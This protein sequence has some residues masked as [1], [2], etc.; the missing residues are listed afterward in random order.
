MGAAIRSLNTNLNEFLGQDPEENRD[1]GN[2]PIKTPPV[3]AH[4]SASDAIIHPFQVRQQH[5]KH[6]AVAP[7]LSLRVNTSI[8]LKERN[9]VSKFG[10]S[11]VA[12]CQ[13][14]QYGNKYPVI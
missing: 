12:F 10:K 13:L 3:S 7:P 4:R 6:L 8:I 14:I 9:E 11:P 5:L 1:T 2:R